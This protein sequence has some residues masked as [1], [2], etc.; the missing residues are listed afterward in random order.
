MIKKYRF[1]VLAAFC[2]CIAVAVFLFY[3]SGPLFNP[4]Y[5][6]K[7]EAYAL[8][9]EQAVQFGATDETF[10][11]DKIKFEDFYKK[12]IVFEGGFLGDRKFEIP[13]AYI[14]YYG[15]IPDREAFKEGGSIH[16]NYTEPN[17]KALIESV[18]TH[19]S[20]D[21]LLYS[22]EYRSFIVRKNKDDPSKAHTW[23]LKNA[24]LS[25]TDNLFGLVAYTFPLSPG[26][27]PN[28]QS[29]RI[30]YV[31]YEGD[32]TKSLI[33]CRWDPKIQTETPDDLCEKEQN[34][35]SFFQCKSWKE[36][37]KEPPRCMH[38]FND[39]NISYALTFPFSDL[40]NWK[41]NRA[42]TIKFFNGFEI[43]KADGSKQ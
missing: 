11:N 32:I 43:K 34:L 7:K 17:K 14:V 2:V 36:K 28:Y 29:K 40:K 37:K 26:I 27:D 6:L 38:F 22:E 33:D 10:K 16:M 21:E 19:K 30:A 9:R 1:Y 8:L 5:K 24:Q 25:S 4:Q 13:K 20:E 35:E 42:D 41:K 31:E 15:K 3:F 39:N 23:F 18:F 12:K